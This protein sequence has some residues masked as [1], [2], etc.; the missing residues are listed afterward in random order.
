ME[1]VT[2]TK[3]KA[4][5]VIRDYSI[6]RVFSLILDKNK[7]I[8]RVIN[9][10]LFFISTFFNLLFKPK[11]SILLIVS[12]PPFLP[13][14]GYILKK[15]RGFR[16]LTLI[17][18]QYP[19]IAVNLGY[20]KKN[21]TIVKIWQKI[22]YRVFDNSYF[23]I[24][25]GKK[26]RKHLI[27]LYPNSNLKLNSVVITNWA[28]KNRLYPLENKSNIKEEIGLKDKFVVQYSGNMGLFHSTEK[29]IEVADLLKDNSE[30]V[31]QLIGGGAKREF[32]K[33]GN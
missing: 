23:V 6:K 20:L 27:D 26:M 2:A 13:F 8:G 19:E 29:I 12:N 1:V 33:D 24:T 28:N 4:R 30:I 14:L 17:H 32:T 18:D 9:C 31:F 10:L 15:I 16:Y 22:N 3:D 21:S 11:N 5:S 25:L 7:K